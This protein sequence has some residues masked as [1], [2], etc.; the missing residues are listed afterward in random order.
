MVLTLVLISII[1]L[2]PIPTAYYIN[3][4][5]SS[6][7]G[8]YRVVPFTGTLQA[9]E[10]VIIDVPESARPYVYGRGWIPDGT[11]LMK[12][13]GALPGDEYS[14][15]S[16]EVLING[17]YVGPICERDSEGKPLPE[18]RG[19]WHIKDGYFLPMST[20]IPNSFDGRYFGA[21]PVELIRCKALPVLTLDE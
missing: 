1:Y 11:P 6:P 7:R 8:I 10:I 16:T 12:K 21:V 2:V 5:Q 4:T 15:T 18:L 13:V 17:K 3:Y 9:G 20:H 19:V 14:I